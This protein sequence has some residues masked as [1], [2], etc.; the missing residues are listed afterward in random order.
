MGDYLCQC[1]DPDLLKIYHRAVPLKQTDSESN[2]FSL[3]D[4]GPFCRLLMQ[5]TS[6]RT[7]SVGI[8]LNAAPGS[9]LP[10]Y[11]T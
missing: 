8:R 3:L 5:Y 6:F 4:D 1:Y 10:W 2:T 7:F 11:F 9:Y